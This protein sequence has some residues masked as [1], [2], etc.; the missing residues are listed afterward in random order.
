MDTE[1]KPR[2]WINLY[3]FWGDSYTQI[4]PEDD[5]GLH[6][7]TGTRCNCNPRVV[8]IRVIHN[9][10]DGRDFTEGAP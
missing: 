8:G 6:S 2:G 9:A 5:I 4:I 1:S 10:F 7:E 3:P